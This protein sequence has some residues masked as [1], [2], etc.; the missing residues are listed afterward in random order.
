[1]MT[2]NLD[3]N[4]HVGTIVPQVF[5]TMLSAVAMPI[6][7]PLLPHSE[8]ISGAVGIEGDQIRGQ[9]YIHFSELLAA[10]AARAMLGM[11]ESE[12]LDDVST[13]D[14][15]GEIANMVVGGLK[16]A[17][18][19]AGLSCAMS[20]PSIM[21]GPSVTVEMPAETQSELFA[22]VC[23]GEILTIEVHLELH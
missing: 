16:S 4:K 17:L 13:N 15:V 2:T 19:D 9:V 10:R 22:F 23:Q 8:R 11:S 7:V 6:P 20:T 21:R 12:L 18:C 14:V 1:M 3:I 5:E